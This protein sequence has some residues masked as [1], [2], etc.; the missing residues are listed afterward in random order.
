MLEA[1]KTLKEADK[2][3]TNYT[4]EERRALEAMQVAL[5]ALNNARQL[6]EKAGYGTF[7]TGALLDADR[8]I[9]YSID[10]AQDRI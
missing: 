4:L 8:A 9:K 10:V 6:S 2:I 7:L 1:I 5:Q 3:M